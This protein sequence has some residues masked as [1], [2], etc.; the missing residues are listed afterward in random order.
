MKDKHHLH[1][2]APICQ[3]DD[4][5]NWKN[6]TVWYAGEPV[7]MKSPYQKFQ[8]KQKDINKWVAKGKFRN[9]DIPYTAHD[10]ETK[11]I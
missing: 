4:N 5:L 3:N 7:C 2:N 9:M 10:L 8:Q 6:D 11:L 1:C